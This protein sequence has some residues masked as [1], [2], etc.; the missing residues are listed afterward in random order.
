[1]CKLTSFVTQLRPRFIKC[2][3]KQNLKTWHSGNTCSTD[4]SIVIHVP[5]VT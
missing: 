5:L 4:T 2:L 1:M 3:K